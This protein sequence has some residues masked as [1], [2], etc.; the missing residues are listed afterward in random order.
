MA[1]INLLFLSLSLSLSLSLWR[2]LSGRNNNAARGAAN[3]REALLT[4]KAR[5]RAREFR[6]SMSRA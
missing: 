2:H 6:E 3:R 5:E 4:Q 1:L